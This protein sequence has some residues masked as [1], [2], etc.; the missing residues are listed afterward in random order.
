MSWRH[1]SI[2][3]KDLWPGSHVQTHLRNKGLYLFVL[4]H[5]CVC[6]HVHALVYW[7]GWLCLLCVLGRREELV[8]DKWAMA[9]IRFSLQDQ[10]HISKYVVTGSQSLHVSCYTC[11]PELFMCILPWQTYCSKVAKARLWTGRCMTMLLS[12]PT[13]AHPY[14]SLLSALSKSVLL[15]QTVAIMILGL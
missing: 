9:E 15:H 7:R 12:N 4:V 3:L 6:V 5:L 13:K 14:P 10:V 11:I 8:I 2:P 1:S